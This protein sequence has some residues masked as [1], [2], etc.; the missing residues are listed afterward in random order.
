MLVHKTRVKNWKYKAGVL[1]CR[2][3]VLLASCLELINDHSYGPCARYY[4][5]CR[6]DFSLSFSRT[7]A[8]TKLESISSSR[9]YERRRE[10]ID[11]KL[12]KESVDKMEIRDTVYIC[13]YEKKIA[14]SRRCQTN[15][16]ARWIFI[17]SRIARSLSGDG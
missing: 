1:F 14:F 2:W 13:M 15:Y 16:N 10:K 4:T 7:D 11:F 3:V 17:A 8:S 12:F 9:K 6:R 5:G